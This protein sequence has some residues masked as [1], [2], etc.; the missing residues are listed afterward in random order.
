MVDKYLPIKS[1]DIAEERNLLQ[2]SERDIGNGDYYFTKVAKNSYRTFRQFQLREKLFLFLGAM[3]LILFLWVTMYGT[4]SM[5]LTTLPSTSAALIEK[6]DIKLKEYCDEFPYNKECYMMTSVINP[7]PENPPKVHA[8]T[9]KILSKLLTDDKE[10]TA[11]WTGSSNSAGHDNY[12]NQSY[13]VVIQERV[14]GIFEK[15]GIEFQSLNTAVGSVGHFPRPLF[16]QPA[17]Y[18]NNADILGFEF[19]MFGA[20]GCDQEIFM[21]TAIANQKNPILVNSNPGG[22]SHCSAEYTQLYYSLKGKGTELEEMLNHIIAPHGWHHGSYFLTDQ[23]LKDDN[24]TN[25]DLEFLSKYTK[26]EKEREKMRTHKP[27]HGLLQERYKDFGFTNFDYSRANKDDSTPFWLS[28]ALVCR[29]RHHP[30]ALGH[31]LAGTQISYWLLTHLKEALI[32]YEKHEQAGTLDQLRKDVTKPI[33]MPEIEEEGCELPGK[34]Q[35]QCYM[36][37]QPRLNEPLEEFI[38]STEWNLAEFFGPDK[39]H[40]EEFGYTD[41]HNHIVIVETDRPLIM[42]FNIDAKM[43]QNHKDGRVW[44]VLCGMFP[45]ENAIINLDGD[46]IE[47]DFPVVGHQLTRHTNRTKILQYEINDDNPETIGANCKSQC[48]HALAPV[49]VGSHTLTLKAK[50]DKTFSVRT[51]FFV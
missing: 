33:P 13:P 28:R 32:I 29:A 3:F 34:M 51:L 6:I 10:F 43:N 31:Y 36:T 14:H 23:Y 7:V 2:E 9:K 50:K 22:P 48:C 15:A 35:S 11:V 41:I 49:H 20:N 38:T 18:G 19:G 25:E 37:V 12:Y 27:T 8:L 17:T 44:V 5:T 45:Q 30:G 26:P 40:R 1:S 24:K 46:I 42:P 47:G 16:C 4:K 21:R 39:A